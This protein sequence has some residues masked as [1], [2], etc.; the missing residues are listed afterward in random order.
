MEDQ[1]KNIKSLDD[2]II[3]YLAQDIS[4]EDKVRLFSLINNSKEK[5]EY[6][7]QQTELWH[8]SRYTRKKEI[9]DSD[10]AFALFQSRTRVRPVTAD[11]PLPM[12]HHLL[13]YAAVLIPFLF[14]GYFTTL[15]FIQDRAE[16]PQAIHTVTAPLGSKTNLK[17]ADG[18]DIWLNSGTTIECAPGFGKKNRNV[19]MTGEAYFEVVKNEQLP[20]IV[21]AGELNVQVL[22]THFNVKA[23]TEEN[24]TIVTLLEG[25]VRLSDSQMKHQT[26]LNPMETAVY[27]PST[28]SMTVRKDTITSM[29][30][31]QNR[32]IFK[33]ET[34]VQI[35]RILQRN[36]NVEIN[37][38]NESIKSRC[39]AGDF[40]ENESLDQI[41]RIMA[42]N[43]KFNYRIKG[44]VVDVY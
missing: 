3:D 33:G 20:F 36:F 19:T 26:L 37:I 21:K 6:F 40:V 23:Y 29:D 9:F 38:H 11:K 13:R 25:L 12:R 17:L 43:G 42:T 5:N 15:Y 16:L 32:I 28:Y 2:L 24:E 18:T 1:I 27:S 44:A 31:M 22:G 35:T 10:Q 14:L 4:E 30:W 34:F 39:F 41:F 8:S 7:R